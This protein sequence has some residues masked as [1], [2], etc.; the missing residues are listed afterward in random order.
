M[1]YINGS[2][3]S[4]VIL[5]PEAIDDYIEE[6]NMVRAVAAFVE[7]LNFK[8]LEFV[9]A[10]PAETG[11]PG[12]DPRVLLGLYLWGHLNGVRSARRLE[13][14][15][16]RNVEVMWLTGKLFPDFKTIA[17]FRKDNGGAL[18]QVLVEFR[19]W[20]D[21]E[22][23]FGK[24]LAAVDGSKFK[25]VNSLGRNYTKERLRKLIKREE[26][27]VDQYLKDLAEA[28]EQAGEEE[29]QKLTAAELKQKIAGIK[30]HLEKHKQL[31]QQLGESGEQQI[32]LTDPEARLM[33]MSKGTDVC[34]NLQA[35][36]DSKHKLIVALEVTNACAD[37]GQLA[38]IAKQAKAALGV[39]E[40]LVVGDGGYF[41]GRTIKECE[42]ARI[43]TYVPVEEADGATARGIF[44]RS[45]FHYDEQRDLYICPA[46]AELTVTSRYKRQQKED[47]EFKL[48]GTARCA[49][50]ALRSQCTT[51]QQGRKIKRW[52]HQAVIE[53]QAARNRAHPEMQRQRGSLIGHVFGTIK[54]AMGHT[55]FLTKGKEKVATEAS[56]MALS[57]N[58]KRVT[59]IMGVAR[60]T[61]SFALKA[62]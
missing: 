61:R 19:L 18:K 14:E 62:P 29:E 12:Y 38:Q 33:R 3:R 57:Y 32:S 39:A 46:G 30:E 42:D 1:G 48:Y 34:Y 28:D 15:C 36:V 53:R 60:M 6:A 17:N 23:L 31:Q 54:R 47:S 26:E 45:K 22:K 52:V 24:E 37:Q 56:L 16:R 59:S 10:E 4:Q 9:R 44:P 43:T 51:S 50:C 49:G 41:E 35:A 27:K 55:H 40:L 20:C 8:E 2:G 11:R 25:A 5:F 13:R 58:F 21:G 7:Y